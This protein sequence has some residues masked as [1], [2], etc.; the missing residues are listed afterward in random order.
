[1]PRNSDT[2]PNV[3]SRNSFISAGVWAT[4]RA[5]MAAI[6]LVQSIS[7]TTLRNSASVAWYG[8]PSMRS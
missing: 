5:R 6:S 3:P 4:S 1:M 7:R 8:V 2:K